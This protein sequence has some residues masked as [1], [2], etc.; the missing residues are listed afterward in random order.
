MVHFFVRE[1]D[2]R[3]AVRA[4][5]LLA[6]VLELSHTITRRGHEARSADPRGLRASVPP[7]FLTPVSDLLEPPSPDKLLSMAV[8]DR[9]I[10]DAI[11]HR[12]DCDVQQLRRGWPDWYAGHLRALDE[13]FGH[14]FWPVARGQM[15][16]PELP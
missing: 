6:A 15:H 11:A 8:P 10:L 14:G 13:V 7:V 1:A 2:F 5:M 3:L 9:G 16:P 12:Y 4:Y